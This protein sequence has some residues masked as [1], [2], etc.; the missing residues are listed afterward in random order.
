MPS[1]RGDA[2]R[3]RL[4]RRKERL[5]EASFTEDFAVLPIQIGFRS[6]LELLLGD[7]K[8]HLLRVEKEKLLNDEAIAR[9][10]NK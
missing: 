5:L 6:L 8:C 9:E 2:E 1:T 7:L 3:D 4:A 10:I